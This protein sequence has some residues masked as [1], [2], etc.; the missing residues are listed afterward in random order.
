MAKAI[1]VL[2]FDAVSNDGVTV[3]WG[4]MYPPSILQASSPCGCE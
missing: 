3:V 2:V 4:Y 1:V